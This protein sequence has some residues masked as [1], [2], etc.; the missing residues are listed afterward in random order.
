MTPDEIIKIIDYLLDNGASAYQEY[1]YVD[2][3]SHHEVVISPVIEIARQ[4]KCLQKTALLGRLAHSAQGLDVKNLYSS[5]DDGAKQ[6]E[7]YS[8]DEAIEEL[9]SEMREQ[10]N[11]AMSHR[12]FAR[13]I[14]LLHSC[15]EVEDNSND[16]TLHYM[17]GQCYRFEDDIQNACSSLKE[18]INVGGLTPAVRL[19]ERI[20]SGEVRPEQASSVYHAYG[21]A[22]QLN[23]DYNTADFALKV[24][25][26]L[27]PYA[28]S[29]YNSLGITYRRQGMLTEALD[30]YNHAEKLINEIMIKESCSTAQELFPGDPTFAMIL[31]N[32]GLCKLDM[33]DLEGAKS[34][35]MLSI[36]ETPEGYPYSEPIDNLSSLL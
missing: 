17:L 13:A 5:G 36:N 30:C 33:K 15:L 1:C 8:S 28:F 20:Q 32:R 7:H 31:N 16:W 12:E 23:E 10:A 27:N 26:Q 29:S 18:A 11:I 19:K 3:D 2:D 4:C 21:I 6:K 22:S 25:I 34:D 35:F 9:P 24:A 14:P